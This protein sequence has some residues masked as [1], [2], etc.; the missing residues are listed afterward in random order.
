MAKIAP[1]PPTCSL[2]YH[3]L[4]LPLSKAHDALARCDEKF[5]PSFLETLIQQEARASIK[6]Q[7]RGRKEKEMRVK[8]AIEWAISQKSYPLSFFCK[9]HRIIKKEGEEVGKVR[10][11]QNWVGEEGSPIEDAWF[12]PPK[13]SLLPRH[14]ADWMHFSKEKKEDPLLQIA[15]LFAQLLILHPFMDGNG[16]LAR[17][18]IPVFLWKRK[19]ISHPFLFM[20]E[21][22]MNNRL[23]YNQKLFGIPEKGGW[24]E[25]IIFF[26]EGVAERSLQIKKSPY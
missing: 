23:R 12:I 7:E 22:F 26:L 3:S 10:T 25:W 24:E 6:E 19:V 2:D 15:L 21:Y 20:S 4:L 11:G 5:I 9:L 16:R 14:L 1:F 13:A 18:F 17:I 8:Q